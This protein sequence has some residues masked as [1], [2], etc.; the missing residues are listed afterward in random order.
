M[1]VTS[2]LF[3]ILGIFCLLMGAV[4]GF[5]GHAVAGTLYLVVLACAFAYLAK[6]TR[7]F[8]DEVADL[9]EPEVLPSAGE[10]G[11]GPA[12][13]ADVPQAHDVAFHASAPTLTPLLFAIGGGLILAGLVFAQWLVLVGGGVMALVAIA[14]FLETGKRREA[15]QA[16]KA[17]HGEHH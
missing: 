9:D 15:E 6:E 14:W 17:G 2:N 3:V 5:W 7:E 1:K 8:G 16:A 11:G 4:L 12:D 10:H 13:L